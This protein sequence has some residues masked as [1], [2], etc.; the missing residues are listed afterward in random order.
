MSINRKGTISKMS[1][2]LA[3]VI[4]ACIGFVILYPILGV[5]LWVSFLVAA[6]LLVVVAGL[7][8]TRTMAPHH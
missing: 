1:T 6:C 7:G 4:A 5:T 8:S 2:L 3:A